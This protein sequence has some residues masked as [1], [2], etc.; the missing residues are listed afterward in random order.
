MAHSIWNGH[1]TFGLVTIPVEL[2]SAEKTRELKFSLLDKRDMAPVGY[3][4]INKSTGAEVPQSSIVKGFEVDDGRFV[5]LEDEDFEKANVEATQSI[6]IT[7][8]VLLEDIQPLLF[9]RPYY[10]RPARKGAHAY[11]LLAATLEETGRVG[12]AQ[13][14]IRSRQHLACLLPDGP[15][16]VLEVLRYADELRTPEDA[17]VD[18]DELE[19]VEVGAKERALAKT[20]IEKMSG[21]W[22]PE[23]YHDQYREDLMERIHAKA[24]AKGRPVPAKGVPRRKSAGKVISLMDVLKQ[25]VEGTSRRRRG[26]HEERKRA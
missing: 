3:R 20:L 9:D 13:V 12:I 10:L 2:L 26:A 24:K 14:V 8:F 22:K 6:E 21:D 18:V 11:R 15:M 25:S 19:K 16:L 5:I 1:I 4:K 17:G 23:Q 7:D